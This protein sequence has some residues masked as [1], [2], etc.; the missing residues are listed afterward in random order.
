MPALAV[1][2]TSCECSPL[3][4]PRVF[5][6]ILRHIEISY[7]QSSGDMT[8]ISAAHNDFI[9]SMQIEPLLLKGVI[10]PMGLEHK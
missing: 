8:G 5:K 4:L 9:A 1:V 6:I 2:M 7:L 3:L 10:N